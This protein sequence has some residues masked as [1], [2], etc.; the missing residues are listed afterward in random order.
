MNHQRTPIPKEKKRVISTDKT[1]LSHEKQLKTLKESINELV[2]K[3]KALNDENELR[4]E[5]IETLKYK[6]QL[7]RIEIEDI[8]K[9]LEMSY[10]YK[11]L[12]L[13]EKALREKN[14]QD[15]KYI[16]ENDDAAE[17]SMKEEKYLSRISFLEKELSYYD[18]D[19]LKYE[20]K[21]ESLEAN[22]NAIEKEKLL[23][24]EKYKELNVLNVQYEQQK[25]NLEKKLMTLSDDYESLKQELSS[26]HF[27]INQLK[28]LLKE[29]EEELESTKFK[30]L[31]KDSEIEKIRK[32]LEDMNKKENELM[33]ETKLKEQE[34][35]SLTEKLSIKEKQILDYKKHEDIKNPNVHFVSLHEEVVS[36]KKQVL[37]Q[38]K[39]IKQLEQE[40]ESWKK[41]AEETKEEVTN[42]QA[43]II[44]N[45]L[46]SDVKNSNRMPTPTNK[47]L[48][49]RFKTG[50]GTVTSTTDCNNTKLSDLCYKLISENRSLKEK[51]LANQVGSPKE[52]KSTP[53]SVNSK[54]II[55]KKITRL[56]SPSRPLKEKN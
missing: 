51:L 54:R 46:T 28:H 8:K 29:K 44:Q 52:N 20:K 32:E 13:K 31:S 4:S 16:Q 14:E 49:S 55:S 17:K 38:E 30:L 6:W 36:L 21:I 5:L 18:K 24:D 33:L 2:N 23:L 10:K 56:C 25:V 34:I 12:Y 53:T 48:V 45:T 1:R 47:V 7:S 41:L 22:L 19:M 9:K 40:K 27:E 26:N 35:I 3:N 11:E 37:E 39:F 43:Y 50:N 15:F 42:V